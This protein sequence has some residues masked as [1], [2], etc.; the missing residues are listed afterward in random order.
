MIRFAS[1]IA[2]ATLAASPALAQECPPPPSNDTIDFGAPQPLIVRSGE[3][4]HAFMVEIA[5]APEEA[6]RGLM[7]R[8]EIAPDQGMLFV[9][10]RSAPHAFYMRNTCASLDILYLREDGRVAS[11]VRHA[12]PFS[13]RSLPSPGPVKAVLEIAAGRSEELGI[14]PGAIVVHALLGGGDALTAP[15]ET[16]AGGADA[17][18]AEGDATMPADEELAPEAPESP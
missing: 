5:D 13:E 12:V 16:P 1:L 6:A 4:E 9:F 10:E 8:P 15:A 2:V 17:A 7:F 18:P 11:I 14:T 3:A